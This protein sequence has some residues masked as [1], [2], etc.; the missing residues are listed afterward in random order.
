MGCGESCMFKKQDLSEEQ[1]IG[2]SGRSLN[3]FLV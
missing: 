3:A 1:K 2:R